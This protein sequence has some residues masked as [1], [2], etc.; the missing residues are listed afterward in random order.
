MGLEGVPAADLSVDTTAWQPSAATVVHV[1]VLQG[2][3]APLSSGR[4]A[5]RGRQPYLQGTGIMCG[6]G[7]GR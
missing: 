6:M 1:L 2:G 4:G 3:T 5:L 7:W